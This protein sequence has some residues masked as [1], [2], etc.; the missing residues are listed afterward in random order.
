[1]PKSSISETISGTATEVFAVIHDYD[2]RL[3]WDTLLQSAYVEE[4]FGKPDVGVV[5]LCKAKKFLGGIELRTK[6]V[7]FQPGKVAAV[8][9]LNKPPF[10]ER[11][12]AS[13]R[14]FRESDKSSIVVYEFNFKAR[15]A[16]LRP[17]LH[18]LMSALLKWETRKRLRALQK[19]FVDRPTTVR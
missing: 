16:I 5:T 14:H 11:F 10:F 19:Y 4:G 1:M 8:V 13:I 6:Y 18:P 9:S 17:L 7:S 2:R 15:P 3:E 12:A